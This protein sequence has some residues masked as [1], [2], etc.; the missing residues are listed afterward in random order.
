MCPFWPFQLM[1]VY[2]IVLAPVLLLSSRAV[3]QISAHRH[4][5][6]QFHPL[7]IKKLPIGNV[8][9]VSFTASG[10]TLQDLERG[11][12]TVVVDSDETIEISYPK[13][14]KYILKTEHIENGDWSS[15]LNITGKF[16]GYAEV[17]LE[18]RNG[19]GDVAKSDG[20]MVT[21]VRPERVIDK[22]FVY[23]VAIL[24]SIIYINFGCALDW[25]VFK[26]T[27]RKPVGPV[28]GFLTQFLLMP[29]VSIFSVYY[30]I[31][32]HLEIA[33]QFILSS[34]HSP[35]INFR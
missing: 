20:L 3:A 1:F 6:V 12:V 11:E 29:V 32:L 24:V 22:V 13:D 2:V 25:S 18:L 8:E 27:I 35:V 5:N 34:R 14:K 19:D 28:I 15:I 33:Y 4:W 30:I 31:F 9:T 23:S 7:E 10:I 17:G 16:L 26:K 21:V